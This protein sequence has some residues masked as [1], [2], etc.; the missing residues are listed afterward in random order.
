[1]SQE[2]TVFVVDDDEAVRKALKLLVESA[3]MRVE[4]FAS[5][6]AF[7][8]QYDPNRP[9]CLVLDIRMPGMSG[10]TLQDQLIA[11]RINIPLIMITGHGDVAMAVGAVKKGAIDFIQKP[12]DDQTLLDRIQQALRID[13]QR[14]EEQARRSEFESRLARLTP[15]EREVLDLLISGKG[16]KEVALELGLSRKTVDIHRAHVMMKLGVDSLLEI[17][18]AGYMS[19]SSKTS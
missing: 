18:R 19:D 15:R 17:A 10:L 7:L 9:G 6:D 8:A 11:R 5:A 13:A 16:N 2:P 12:F 3:G 1:M 4:T 14:R